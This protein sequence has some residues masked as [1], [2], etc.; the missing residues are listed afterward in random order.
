MDVTCLTVFSEHD[1]CV[2]ECEYYIAWAIHMPV[3]AVEHFKRSSF[4]LTVLVN[5]G[6]EKSAIRLLK[7]QK[8]AVLS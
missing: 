2:Q 5:L 3:C 4:H 6:S 1:V 8:L 7:E